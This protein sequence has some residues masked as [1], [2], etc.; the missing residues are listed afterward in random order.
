MSKVWIVTGNF[1]GVEK[2]WAVMVFDNKVFANQY[3]AELNAED[4]NVK[5]S[6]EEYDVESKV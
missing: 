3:A 5:Y 1:Y 2:E 4:S 6:V